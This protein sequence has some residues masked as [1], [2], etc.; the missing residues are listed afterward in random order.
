MV[1]G[2]YLEEAAEIALINSLAPQDW[3]A[4]NAG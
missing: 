3:G 1:K 4:F 2:I